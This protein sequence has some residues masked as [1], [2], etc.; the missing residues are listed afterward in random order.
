MRG[1]RESIAILKD[2]VQ[3]RDASPHGLPAAV[4][5]H[6]EHP[7]ELEHRLVQ[8]A[9]EPGIGGAWE[10]VEREVDLL[11]AGAWHEAERRLEAVAHAAVAEEVVPRVV[12]VEQ[13][14]ARRRA[15][16]GETPPVRRQSPE[17]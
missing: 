11:H 14:Y 4:Q 17:A 13:A 5:V 6:D 1:D 10:I 7:D 3:G 2:K 16:P 15:R 9:G 8:P 12:R